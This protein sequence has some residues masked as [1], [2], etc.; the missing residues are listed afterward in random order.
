ML[1]LGTA[2]LACPVLTRLDS[3][4]ALLYASDQLLQTIGRGEVQI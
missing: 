3:K 4:E 1:N 2:R